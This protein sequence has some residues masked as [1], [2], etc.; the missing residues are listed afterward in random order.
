[1]SYFPDLQTD[2]CHG[3]DFIVQY[4]SSYTV[5]S[6]NICAKIG[7]NNLNSIDSCIR[8]TVLCC[9]RRDLQEHLHHVKTGITRDAHLS[10][11][12]LDWSHQT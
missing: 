12:S 10:E 2:S 6:R 11:V 3:P 7:P 9:H 1:M 4:S 8:K 5:S